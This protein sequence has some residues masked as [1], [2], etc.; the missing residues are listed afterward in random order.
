MAKSVFDAKGLDYRW[1]VGQD[2]NVWANI[3]GIGVQNLGKASGVAQNRAYNQGLDINKEI[4]DPNKPAANTPSDNG[5]YGGGSSSGPYSTYNA[6]EEA[7]KANMRS[8]YDR[9]INDINSNLD[10]MDR[11]LENSLAGVRGEYDTYK[12]EQQSS[13]NAE[14]NSHDKE[15]LQNLQNLQSNRNQITNNA[16]KALRGLLSVLGGMGLGDS[17]VARYN[18]PN[19]VREQANTEYG[20]AGKTY[21]QNQQNLDTSWNNYQNQFENDRK[22]LEDWYNG[23]VKAKKQENYEKRQSLLSDLV[24]AYGNRAQYGGDYSGNVNSAYDRIADYRN[25][26]NDLGQY[27]K[28]NYT[29]I[30]SVYNAPDL[31]SYNA[32]NVE[33]TTKVESAE[34]GETSP[35]L[36][37]LR[38]LKKKETNPYG[39]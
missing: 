28:P 39:V 18:V 4:N 5:Y 31:A 12:N 19:M 20:D 15:V 30:T 29:G 21:A 24:S 35:V 2:N 25:K 7:R 11:Q 33:L 10:S 27:A 8:M 32:N 14:K 26:I 22:K 17:S 37:A 38:G 6:E 3:E 36:T 16:S 1:W 23:Q 34:P 9:Q 13:Y